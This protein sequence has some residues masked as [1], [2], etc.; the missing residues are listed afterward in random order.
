MSNKYSIDEVT[1][2]M[3]LDEGIYNR[4]N[5]RIPL[6]VRNAVL[7]QS[8]IDRL[9]VRKIKEVCIASAVDRP[10]LMKIKRAAPV[11][12]PKLREEA[13]SY[14]T[15]I[16][17]IASGQYGDASIASMTV[18]Q[19]DN[20][21]EQLVSSLSKERGSL[22]NIID[23]KSY[24]EYTYHH[25]LSVAVVSIAIAQQL[26]F[27]KNDLTQI[28]KCAMMHDIGKTRVPIELINKSSSLD[29]DEYAIVKTHSEEGFRYLSDKGIG[30]EELWMA[31]MHH[32]EKMDGSGYPDGLTSADIPIMSRIIAVADVY[33]ALTS[34]RPYRKPTQPMEALELIMGGA[35]DVFDFDVVRAFLDIMEPY[36]VGCLIELSN[37]KICTVVNS[38]FPIRPVVQ[39]LDNGHM[40]DLSRDHQCL[41]LVI[42]HMFINPSAQEQNH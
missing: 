12:S 41:D 42:N 27:S 37:G 28:G 17:A 39:A 30:D 23:L 19:L 18:K 7:T 20:V 14:L 40:F 6:L 21:V 3:V 36:P 9:K 29:P 16:F 24:D 32:H 2:G 38:D 31:V 25:S 22:I 10:D 4:S 33:D 35:S 8:R 26:G 13:I 1:E 11:I 34:V 5:S 15:D